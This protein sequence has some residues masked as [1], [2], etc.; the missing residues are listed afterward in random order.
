MFIMEMI[1]CIL[2]FMKGCMFCKYTPATLKELTNQDFP[3]YFGNR[4]VLYDRRLRSIQ[5]FPFQPTP[6]F[7]HSHN[8]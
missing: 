7:C 3:S 1:L 4:V 5:Y 6:E 8:Q 2:L